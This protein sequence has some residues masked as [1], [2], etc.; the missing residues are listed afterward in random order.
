M[1]LPKL[2][3]A[4]FLALSLYSCDNCEDV[5][6]GKLEFTNEL[7]T[8]LP[9]QPAPGKNY[10]LTS[11][12]GKLQMKYAEENTEVII[13]AGKTNYSGKFDLNSCKEY[14]T[15]GKKVYT[16]QVAGE[17]H[18]SIRINYR[19]DVL[20]EQYNTIQDKNPVDDVIE[21]EMGYNNIYPEPVPYGTTTINSFSAKCIFIFSDAATSAIDRI[22]Y[23]QEFLP[24]VTLNGVSHANVYHLY[25]K[26]PHVEAH[27]P[28]S[29]KYPLDFVEGIYIKEGVGLI[30]A[31]TFRGKQL[32]VT[33]E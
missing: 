24:T 13:P 17:K 20:P 28:R 10:Y 6:L 14:Y 12:T 23:M 18:F 15:A 27:E 1:K 11:D 4:V 9:S 26:E 33:V 3:A 22:T 30:N 31:Y 2:L 21:F 25:I 29:D 8:F 16:S 32:N 19:K 7:T 5:N